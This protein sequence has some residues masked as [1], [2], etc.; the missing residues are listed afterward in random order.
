MRR[1]PLRLPLLALVFAG[2]A[3]PLLAVGCG[4]GDGGAADSSPAPTATSPSP[5]GEGPGGGDAGADAAPPTTG[6]TTDTCKDT[7][8][9]DGWCWAVDNHPMSTVTNLV[10]L[11]DA[12]V[13]AT[14]GHA[15]VHFDGKTWSVRHFDDA[16]YFSAL[17]GSASALYAAGRRVT[18]GAA[19]TTTEGVLYHFDGKAWSEVAKTTIEIS[20]MWSAGPN[21]VWLGT[22]SKGIYHWDGAKVTE[23][24][25]PSQS[26]GQ[27]MRAIGGSGPKDVWAVGDQGDGTGPVR[28]YDGTSWKEMAGPFT[29]GHTIDAVRA[30]APNDVWVGGG[31]DQIHHYDGETWTTLPLPSGLEGIVVSIAG[32]PN[33]VTFALTRDGGKNHVGDA[34]LLHWDGQALTKVTAPDDGEAYEPP[35]TALATTPSGALLVSRG[36]GDV[37]RG[38]GGTFARLTSG[39]QIDYLTAASSP[40]GRVA[41]TGLSNRVVVYENGAWQSKPALPDGRLFGVVASDAS[42]AALGTNGRFVA[43]TAAGTDVST[44]FG[45][46]APG[47]LVSDA[48]GDLWAAGTGGVW[49]RTGGAWTALPASTALSFFRSLLVT[50]AGT[51]YATTSTPQALMKLDGATWTKAWTH[52][53]RTAVAQGTSIWAIGGGELG[54]GSGSAILHD[55]VVV[56]IADA[57][58]ARTSSYTD[59]LAVCPDGRVYASYYGYEILAFDGTTWKLESPN[60]AGLTA[61]HCDAKGTVWGFGSDGVVVKKEAPKK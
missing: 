3:A 56:P 50:S 29:N 53:V 31:Y 20:A 24:F 34:A 27:L 2:F 5:P 23:A 26:I 38:A 58:L 1:H 51:V 45:T 61:L 4:S 37:Y 12:D 13:W 15:I 30:F 44:P 36:A 39:P 19:G 35:L 32:K 52:S 33:D 14:A 46:Q 18:T 48:S 47:A 57:K 9:P 59:V 25:A 7:R 54:V 55:D 42:I 60:A 16:L 28:H 8:N 11:A 17:S 43:L 6:T 41:A 22:R 49:H 21:D 10:P 40:S